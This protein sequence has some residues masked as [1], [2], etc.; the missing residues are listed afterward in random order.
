[1]TIITSILL[2]VF[3][4]YATN[5]SDLL[6]AITVRKKKA[7]AWKAQSILSFFS[8]IG[9][10]YLTIDN[11]TVIYWALLLPVLLILLLFKRLNQYCVKVCL[12]VHTFV[13]V[14]ALVTIALVGI[15]YFVRQLTVAFIPLFIFYFLLRNTGY[16]HHYIKRMKQ[17]ML[18]PYTVYCAAFTFAIYSFYRYDSFSFTLLLTVLS[19]SFSI[20]YQLKNHVIYH[21]EQYPSINVKCDLHHLPDFSYAGYMYGEKSLDEEAF[22]VFNATDFGILPGNGENQIIKIQQFVDEVGKRGGGTA[23]FPAGTYHMRSCEECSYITLDYSNVLVKGEMKNGKHQTIFISD[24]PTLRG[25]KNPWLSPFL[26]TTG[27][28]IQRSNIFWGVQFKHKKDIVTKSASMTDPGSDGELLQPEWATKITSDLFLGDKVIEVKDALQIK[29]NYILIVAY[30]TNHEGRLI[31]QI[32]NHDD[33]LPSWGT[34]L[35][36]GDEKA[37]SLQWLVEIDRIIDNHKVVLKQPL[38]WNIG[39][40]CS[41]EVFNVEMLEHVGF[42]DLVIKSTWSGL[43]RHHGETGYYS[44]DFAQEMDYGWNAVNMKRVAHGTISNVIIDNFSNPL[45]VQDSR[46]I[47]LEDIVVKGADGHQGL[48][49]YGHACDNLFSNVTF[50]NHYA[51][52]IGGETCSYG[53]VFSGVHYLNPENKYADFDFHGFSEGPFSPPMQNLFECCTGIRGI[54][55]AGASYNVPSAARENVFWNILSDGYN[56]ASELF[57]FTYHSNVL[58][59]RRK[60]GNCLRLKSIKPF[61]VSSVISNDVPHTPTYSFFCKTYIMGYSGANYITIDNHTEDF[62]DKYIH[63]EQIN[64]GFVAPFSLYRHQLKE[65]QDSNQNRNS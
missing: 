12:K 41:P 17:V 51:D 43:F 14:L 19:F 13:L 26:F 48:K 50:Y 31:K 16:S 7:S 21:F 64:K 32:L 27:E 24:S 10:T 15:S 40:E 35:R 63:T 61:F 25:E 29:S 3:W 37:P 55:G 30:N 59:L 46:N 65:R 38:R 47:T 57:Y 18:S 9:I 23:Y 53:N 22:V 4:G 56:G 33:L 34:A 20:Y 52:F 42:K 62:S 5:L 44:M 28:R 60:L 39:M 54:K 2:A 1:M 6:E 49:L 11:H 36:A 8:A 45:Y 58:T